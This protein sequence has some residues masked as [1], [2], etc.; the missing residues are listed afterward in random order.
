MNKTRPID[1]YLPN[2]MFVFV[3]SAE[4]IVDIQ[5]SNFAM[6]F[7]I[8]KPP[9]PSLL[10]LVTKGP[11]VLAQPTRNKLLKM[12]INFANINIQFPM[13]VSFFLKLELPD[14]FLFEQL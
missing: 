9:A 7:S 12:K 3:H 14:N 10:I 6:H 4:P 13:T 8:V 1:Y 2:F 5:G 11:A